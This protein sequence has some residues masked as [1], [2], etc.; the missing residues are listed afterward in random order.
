MHAKRSLIPLGHKV[1]K[2]IKRQ[3]KKLPNFNNC[4]HFLRDTPTSKSQIYILCSLQTKSKATIQTDSIA[5]SKINIKTGFGS[6]NLVDKTEMVVLFSVHDL[7]E[8][9]IGFRGQLSSIRY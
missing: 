5:Y 4:Y 1:D 3:E 7:Q 8:N 6:T 2:I 9:Q